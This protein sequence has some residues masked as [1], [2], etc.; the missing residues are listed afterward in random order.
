MGIYRLK[1]TS[2]AGINRVTLLED[3]VYIGRDPNGGVYIDQTGATH[4][5]AEIAVNDDDGVIL[6][7]LDTSE[8]VLRNGKP[9]REARLAP[10]D[11]IRAG[12]CRWLLQAPGLRPERVLSE[13]PAESRGARRAWM[14]AGGLVVAAIA[15]AWA[16]GWIPPLQG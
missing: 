12:A 13:Q 14:L 7:V 5:L 11:E 9:V 1:G 8:Q 3:P 10:G 6:T 15:V 16:L 4:R 2:G